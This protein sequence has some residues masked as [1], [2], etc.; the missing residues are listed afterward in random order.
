ME[1]LI[2]NRQE[3]LEISK[4]LKQ[5]IIKAIETCIKVEKYNKD[6]EISNSLDSSLNHTSVLLL[7]RVSINW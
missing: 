4:E 2:N 7:L 6:L 1:V 3:D 5:N